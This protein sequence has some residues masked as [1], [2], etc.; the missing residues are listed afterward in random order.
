[1]TPRYQFIM[2]RACGHEETVTLYGN[3]TR[4]N[5]QRRMARAEVCAECNVKV[6]STLAEAHPT[7]P[8]LARLIEE[9]RNEDPV[10]PTCY[11]RVHNRHNRS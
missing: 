5:E 8:V 6:R 7:N 11:N 9:V 10:N 1:M 3:R 2:V 4:R